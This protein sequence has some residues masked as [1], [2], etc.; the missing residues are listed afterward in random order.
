LIGQLARAVNDGLSATAQGL[1]EGDATG[2]LHAP[3]HPKI[4]AVLSLAVNGRPG[5]TAC[6]GDY[7][8]AIDDKAKAPSAD[9]A[10]HD[11]WVT[12]VLKAYDRFRIL[13]AVHEGDWGTHAINLSVQRSLERAGLLK[14]KGEWYVGRP[15]MVTR[16]DH[17]LGVFNGDVGVALP[18]PA[19]PAAL[20]VYFLDGEKLRSVGVSRLANVETAFAMTVHKSQGSEFFHTALVLPP[21]GSKVLTKELVYTGITRAQERLTL[22]EAQEGLFRSAIDS[23]SK[24]VSGLE[25]ELNRAVH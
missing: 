6:Y 7:L 10:T 15:V 14:P 17:A 8:R 3:R 22:F 4:D 2:V 20:R 24:R 23:P 11:L 19:G 1:F 13:C 16:N 12:A 9:L 18:S 21:G 25:V 5:A